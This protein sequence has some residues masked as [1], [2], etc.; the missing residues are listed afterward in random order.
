MDTSQAMTA[1]PMAELYKRQAEIFTGLI[2]APILVTSQ[3]QAAA[4]LVH[5]DAWNQLIEDIKHYQRLVRIE[6]ARRDLDLGNGYTYE[7]VEAMLR[8]ES[9]L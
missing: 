8:Q 5:P 1:V 6:R 2:D 3:K 4:V 9:I 7:Q